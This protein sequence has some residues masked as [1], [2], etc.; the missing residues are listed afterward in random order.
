MGRAPE[1]MAPMGEAKLEGDS[2]RAGLAQNTTAHPVPKADT[3]PPLLAR[4]SAYFPETAQY[5][6]SYLN[7]R[8]RRC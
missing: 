5:R 8:L 2:G 1:L 4:C 3:H 7:G 6:Q